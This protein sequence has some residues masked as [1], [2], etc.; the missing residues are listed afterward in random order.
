MVSAFMLFSSACSSVDPIEINNPVTLSTTPADMSCY[1]WLNDEEPAFE[2]I[3]AS[4]SC[5]MFEEDGCGVLYFGY[6]GCAYCQRAVPEL[7]TAAEAC[8]VTVY[9]VDVNSPLNTNADFRG[10]LPYIDSALVKTPEGKAFMVPLVIAVKDG[11]VVGSHLA[12]VDGY[13]IDSESSQ[14]S[15]EQKKELQNIYIELFRQASS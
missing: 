6:V 2:E 1:V 9:Y 10:L 8:G 15:R 5:R 11:E 7:N 14:M 4:E 12:L 13:N 3:T